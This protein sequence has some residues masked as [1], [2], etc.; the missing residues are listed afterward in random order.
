MNNFYELF[1]VEGDSDLFHVFRFDERNESYD[2]L[3]SHL[4]KKLDST[5]DFADSPSTCDDYADTNWTTPILITVILDVLNELKNE[6][7]LN[8]KASDLFLAKA[9]EATSAIVEAT[10]NLKYLSNEPYIYV[11]K[12]ITEQECFQLILID[13]NCRVNTFRKSQDG[14][15]RILRDCVWELMWSLGIRNSYLEHHSSDDLKELGIVNDDYQKFHRENVR[16]KIGSYISDSKE[17]WIVENGL[18]SARKYENK[19]ALN[20]SDYI[21]IIELIVLIKIKTLEI[22]KKRYE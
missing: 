17:S 2:N 9:R 19:I 3:P 16:K 6:F 5:F 4:A 20:E 12:N 7:D 21:E 13:G 15:A 10:F 8:G 11:F 22:F 18:N 1:T 14:D